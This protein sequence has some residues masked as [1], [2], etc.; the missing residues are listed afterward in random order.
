M[1]LLRRGRHTVIVTPRVAVKGS[2]GTEYVLGDPITVPNVS[3]QP[4]EASEAE[5]V[6]VQVSTSYRVL[7]LPGAWPGGPLSRVEVLDGPRPGVYAQ[8]GEARA[9]GM[10]PAT[11]HFDVLITAQG[12]EDR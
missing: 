9:Y 2:M 11:A 4:V 5:S 10:S 7:G 3:V 12:T 1:S 6:G 8:H